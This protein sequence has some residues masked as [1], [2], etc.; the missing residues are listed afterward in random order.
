MTCICQSVVS[1]QYLNWTTRTV[2]NLHLWTTVSGMRLSSSWT[3]FALIDSSTQS[4]AFW[5][6]WQPNWS[7][8]NWSVLPLIAW[9]MASI[10]C[11]V[12]CSK[13]LWTR[14]F[15]KRLIMRE[16]ADSTMAS[17]IAYFCSWVPTLSFC[18]RNMDACWSLLD[19]IFSTMYFQLQLTLL[20][21]SRL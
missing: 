16:Y 21:R 8:L 19:T 17:T 7:I 2:L 6:T 13:H 9:A 14:K 10:C 3:I 1:V 5:I 15:P 20:S 18:C 11:C 12:P 4:K